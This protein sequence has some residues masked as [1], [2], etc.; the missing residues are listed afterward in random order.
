MS[1]TGEIF[2]KEII[3][4]FKDMKMV[5]SVFILPIV[6]MIGVM[7]L[8]GNVV[9]NMMNDIEEHQS[10][11]YIQNE[12]GS[13]Q[14]FLKNVD[15]DVKIKNTSA[16]NKKVKEDILNGD[17]DLLIEF[18]DDF[19]EFIQNYKEGDKVPQIKAY[20]NPSEDYSSAAYDKIA[21]EVLESYRQVLLK[22]R[23]GNLEQI[24]VFTVNS[25]NEEMIIQDDA[26]AGGKALGTMLPYFVTMMLFA[27][28]MGIGTDMIAGE[29]ERGTMASL[30]VSP[31]KRRSIIF[32]KVFALMTISGLSA[33][34]S[35][36]A[37]V[38][39]MPMLSK[40]MMGEGSVN[41]N[42][43]LNIRQI[44]MLGL[45]LVALSFLYSTI[46]SLVSVFAKTVKEAS[47]Y[48]SPIYTVVLV[49]G[50]L[51][52]YMTGDVPKSAYYIPIYNSAVVLKQILT[53]EVT[54]AQYGIT[55]AITLGAGLVLTGVIARAFESEKV[56]SA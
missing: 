48:V 24:A 32:G 20:Y 10:I 14:A 53:Q 29:K 18:P 28:A 25:D 49:I 31:I 46:I 52:M 15:L 21:L 9:K 19:D 27:G 36:A 37:M 39:C 40:S 3:R 13:F 6:V 1:G 44:I 8:M 54:M 47:S 38:I 12:P 35:T 26:K 34:I 16:D 5:F 41:V 55:L 17:V 33:V 11:V 50:I 2:K 23:V 22:E 42:M 30:L 43:N 51:T 56:M 45:L 4:I 7:Y